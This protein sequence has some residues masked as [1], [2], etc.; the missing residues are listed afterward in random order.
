MTIINKSYENE[1][2]LLLSKMTLREKLGQCIMIEPIFC[3]EE[4]NIEK[5]KDK[6]NGISDPK[7]LDKLFNEYHVG[8]LLYGGVSR[9]GEDKAE[10]WASYI[11][12][13]DKYVSTTRLQIPLLYGT[14]AI[15]G[16]NFIKGATIFPHNLGVTATWNPEL[17]KEYAKVV[18]KELISTGINC[19]FAPTIDVARDQRWGR[20]YES[21]GE[22][23]YLAS[24]ISKALVEGMQD[25]NKVAACAKHFVGYGESSNGMDR[26][27]ANLSERSILETHLPPFESAVKADVSAIMV[28]GG[29]VN[30]VPMPVSKKLLTGVLRENLGFKGITMSDWEDVYRLV[31]R[32]KVV[33]NRKEAIK[34]AFNAGLDMNMAV[35]DLK[36]V[37]VMEDLVHEGEISLERVNQ[38]VGNI[39]RVKFK[40]GLFNKKQLDIKKTK[41][42]CGS[43]ESKKIAKKL[44]LESI[45]LLKN[46][47]SLL[48]LSKDLKSIIVTGITADSKRHLCGGWTLSWASADEK[49]LNCLT[50]LDAIKNSVSKDT[51]VTYVKNIAELKNL[52]VKESDYDVCIS[53]VGEEP[54]SEWLGDSMS[55]KIDKDEELM[56]KAAFDTGIDVVMVSILG[57]PQ[58]VVWADENINSILWAY[59]PGT[60][61]ATAI[62][63]VV[64][65]DYNPAGK[66]TISF[67]KNGNQIPVVYNARRYECSEITTKYEPL[68]PFGYGLSYTTFE[69]SNLRVPEKIIINKELNISIDVKNSGKVD[70]SEVVLLYLKDAYASVTRP[71][72]SLKAYK[73]I[74]LKVGKK[75]TVK[76][77]ISLKELG[78]Y[79]ENLDFVQ[80][81]RTIE[82][83]IENLSKEFEIV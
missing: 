62:T 48:P 15:H 35:S 67:P 59:L 45:T 83:M 72:K 12:G 32:H 3:V 14:D 65:G 40:L 60:Q 4:L 7:F 16:V 71:L 38:A 75:K 17:V 5:D 19:N 76:F 77:T 58:N 64:F 49:D 66:T 36:A 20:V 57:R 78:L 11:S 52:K 68:Y 42:L 10:D 41:E 23:P 37:D 74:N 27:P 24:T 55:M 79:D 54:H 26:T 81:K 47:N 80:E 61:G 43:D 8:M 18:S 51:K 50:I 1:I 13:I 34:R 30:G 70:G 28:N 63:E 46:D 39:L 22:D 6:F 33:K 56:L 9:V 82:V 69:Y 44:A 31:S 2:K 29:D 21:L 73:K 25:N 53:V